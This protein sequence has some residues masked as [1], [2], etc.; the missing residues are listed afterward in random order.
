[1]ADL[2]ASSYA[3]YLNEVVAYDNCEEFNYLF[4]IPS[5]KQIHRAGIKSSFRQ[6]DENTASEY[7]CV[8]F[9]YLRDGAG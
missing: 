9:S 1:M 7:T 3:I 2:K 6:T 8:I 5:G 4:R